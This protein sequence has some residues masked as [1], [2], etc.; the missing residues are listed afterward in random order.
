MSRPLASVRHVKRSPVST[1]HAGDGELLRARDQMLERYELARFDFEW[2]VH[3]WYRQHEVKVYGMYRA[4]IVS[5]GCK[6]GGMRRP[7]PSPCT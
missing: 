5:M 4:C 7:M 3:T 6:E 1:V 2:S